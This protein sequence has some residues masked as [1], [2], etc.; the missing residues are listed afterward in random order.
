MEECQEVVVL[1]RFELAPRNLG[2]PL[3]N[4]GK[5]WRIYPR[6]GKGPTQWVSI[7]AI[8]D[9][10][11]QGSFYWCSAPA[12]ERVINDVAGLAQPINEERWQLRFE[13]GAVAHLVYSMS[14]SLTRC[15]ELVY[16]V[17]Q[18][19]NALNLEVS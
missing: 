10:P 17:W 6:F 14:L 5:S 19:R 15:P 3:P 16:E 4:I 2:K 11:M 8:R 9:A 1:D 13:A 18:S 7:V 12:H